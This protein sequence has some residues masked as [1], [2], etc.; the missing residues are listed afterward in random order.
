MWHLE[1]RKKIISEYPEIKSLMAP[2]FNTFYIG[3]FVVIIQIYLGS[4][5]AN[6]S[7]NFIKGLILFNIFFTLHHLLIMVI[8]EV[9][10]NIVFRNIKYN[11]LFLLY[12]NIPLILPFSLLYKRFHLVHHSLLNKV[13]D[14]DIPIDLEMKYIKNRIIRFFWA[15]FYTLFYAIRPF[16]KNRKIYKDDIINYICQVVIVSIL[17]KVVGK[18]GIIL[19]LTNSLFLA[20]GIHPL[21]VHSL[22]EHSSDKQETVSYYGMLNYLMM[23]VGYHVEHHDFPNIPWI[24]LPKIRKIAPEYY[25]K[26]YYRKSI[27]KEIFYFILDS[28][29]FDR[30]NNSYFN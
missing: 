28:K 22:I 12:L 23:N 9:T 29:V 16:I 11:K 6:K 4:I 8:H 15:F 3:F 27:I 18:Y 7:Y 25:D 30:K 17:Y 10:H 24:N 1:R 19:M 13:S 21:S 26:L 2:Y 14:P 20:C 5:L